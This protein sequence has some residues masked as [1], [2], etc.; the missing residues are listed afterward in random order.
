MSPTL[1]HTALASRIAELRAKR[2][3]AQLDGQPFNDAAALAEAEASL[4]AL[5]DAEAEASR[6]GAERQRQADAARDA[7]LRSKVDLAMLDYFKAITAAEEAT[8]TLAASVKAALTAADAVSRAANEFQHGAAPLV[9][10]KQSVLLR[11]SRMISNSLREIDGQSSFGQIELA[12]DAI[13]GPPANW[14]VTEQRALGG[15]VASIFAPPPISRKL[16]DL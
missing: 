16:K 9:L 3:A 10:S 4:A 14:S 1:D 6:R 12:T 13:M 8:R 11:L 15:S 7:G 2:G 5:E